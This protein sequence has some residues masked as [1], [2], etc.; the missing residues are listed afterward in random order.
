MDP[1]RDYFLSN[2]QWS[3]QRNR[4]K[5]KKITKHKQTKDLS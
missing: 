5:K 1:S 2:P 3:L 4:Q